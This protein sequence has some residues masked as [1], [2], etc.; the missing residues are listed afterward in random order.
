MNSII[1]RFNSKYTPEPNT[2]CWLWFGAYHRLGYGQF[3]YNKVVM[4]SHRVSF[5]LF[6][7]KFDD[8]LDVLH[9]CDTRSCVNPDHL[10]LGDHL[11]NM[12]DAS[13]KGRLLNQ[14]KTHCPSGHEYAGDNLVMYRNKR[15]CLICRRERGLRFYHKI[16]RS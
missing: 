2:G 10:F 15:V 9:S 3:R 8:K 6:R 13:K 5:E 1:S 12:R 14:R 7:G 11:M 16:K 4:L